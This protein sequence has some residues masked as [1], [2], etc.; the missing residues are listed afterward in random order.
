[1]SNR[2]YKLLAHEESLASAIL[3][4]NAK[5]V[6]SESLRRYLRTHH[7]IRATPQDIL[8]LKNSRGEPLYRYSRSLAHENLNRCLKNIHGE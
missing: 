8:S 1:M 2:L 5:G 4:A 6:P 3:T 7:G